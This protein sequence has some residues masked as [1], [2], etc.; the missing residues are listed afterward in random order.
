MTLTLTPARA[1][2]LS[3]TAYSKLE[4]LGPLIQNY[5]KISLCIEYKD[6]Q[7]SLPP[8]LNVLLIRTLTLTL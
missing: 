2:A 5:N 4:E 1:L 8:P 3:L 7:D 6:L